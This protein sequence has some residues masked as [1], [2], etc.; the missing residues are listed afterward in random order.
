MS[1]KHNAQ[2]S[3]L[4]MANQRESDVKYY[5]DLDTYWASSI[6]T[7]LDKLR[8]FTKYV[9]FGEFPKFLAKYEIFKK[10]LH[11]HGGIIECGVHQ[12]G[13]LMTWALLS[14]IFEPVNHIRKIIGFDTFEGFAS[15]TE[16]DFAPHNQDAKVGGLAVDAHADIQRAIKIY[17]GFRPLGHINKVELVK[18]DA[19]VTIENYIKANPHLVV[20]LLYLDFDVYTPTKRAIELLRT[21]M[22]V[23]SIIAFDELYHK[24]WP[25][26][27]Q[28]VMDTLGVSSLKIERFPFH[29][30]ISYAVLT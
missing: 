4:A 30:Q 20:S 6:G 16:K 8:A 28:A 5:N 7:S 18:G 2:Y 11:I 22:P 15:I 12:G 17:D 9:P 13:G 10:I 14:S 1:E 25:G 26:E 29:P 24:D 3:M 21:R 23:G 19:N 27:T